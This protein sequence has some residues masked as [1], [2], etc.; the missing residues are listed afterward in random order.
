MHFYRAGF[1]Y[2]TLTLPAYDSSPIPL[3]ST[4]LCPIM[5]ILKSTASQAGKQGRVYFGKGIGRKEFCRLRHFSLKLLLLN[6]GN[7]SH[8]DPR[9]VIRTSKSSSP[10]SKMMWEQKKLFIN[11][12]RVYPPFQPLYNRTLPITNTN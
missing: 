3:C 4:I 9:Q 11:S 2:V 1:N 12:S 10:L 8:L 6:D 7:I 5:P